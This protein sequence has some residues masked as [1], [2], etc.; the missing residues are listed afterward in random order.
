MKNSLSVF[1][2]ETSV[3]YDVRNDVRSEIF[4]LMIPRVIEGILLHL[5]LQK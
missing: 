1:F 2:H 3:T 4:L 5:D